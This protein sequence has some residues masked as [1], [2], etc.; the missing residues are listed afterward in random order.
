M[1]NYE[2]NTFT[3]LINAGQDKSILWTISGH[4][5]NFHLTCQLEHKNITEGL[6]EVYEGQFP[7]YDDAFQHAHG[8]ARNIAIN[9]AMKENCTKAS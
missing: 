4:D 9:S 5:G 3:G 6:E 2:V 7:S 8:I 1:G